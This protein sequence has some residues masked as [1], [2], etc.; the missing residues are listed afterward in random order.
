MDN[1]ARGAGSFNRAFGAGS[2]V[3]RSGTG[4]IGRG[5]A[6]FNRG[7]CRWFNRP[8]ERDWFHRPR[9]GLVSSAAGG[10]V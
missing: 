3:P 8:A 1:I 7:W 4:F 2:I 5:A 6:W 9:A 10:L